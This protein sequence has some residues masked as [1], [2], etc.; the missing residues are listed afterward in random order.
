MEDIVI[1]FKNFLMQSETCWL[2]S[3]SDLLSFLDSLV[4]FQRDYLAKFENAF[5]D[6]TLVGNP[7]VMFVF[8]VGT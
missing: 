4:A 1:K 8:I 2:E 6:S 3:A 7:R 5:Y